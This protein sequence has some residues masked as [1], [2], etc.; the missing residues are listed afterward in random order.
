MHIIRYTSQSL[1][2]PTWGMRGKIDGSYSEQKW[3]LH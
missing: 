1:E 3:N 2:I